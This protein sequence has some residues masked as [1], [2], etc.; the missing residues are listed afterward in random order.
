MGF[1]AGDTDALGGIG[2]GIPVRATVTGFGPV[3]L[4]Q[5]LR[6]NRTQEQSLALIFHTVA[7]SKGL[8][9]IDLKDLRPVVTFLTSDE[10]RQEP[11]T[12][13]AVCSAATAWVIRAVPRPSRRRA[14]PV[15][16]GA[17]VRHGRVAADG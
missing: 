11:K 10:G 12:I 9:L 1:P 6:L 7:D 2:R 15:S 14:R 13:S 4:S 3:L 8:E 17:G 5:A 16:S